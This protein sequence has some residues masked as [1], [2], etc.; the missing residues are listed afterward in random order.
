MPEARSTRSNDVR[1]RNV[2]KKNQLRPVF[3][4][5][6]AG[7]ILLYVGFFDDRWSYG[8]ISCTNGRESA[9][10]ACMSSLKSVLIQY[11]SD[12]SRFPHLK[13]ISYST[14]RVDQENYDEAEIVLEPLTASRNVLL[15]PVIESFPD[16]DYPGILSES[17]QKRWKGP[18][19][20]SKFAFL[21]I[22]ATGSECLG[23]TFR[24]QG[25]CPRNNSE[26][27]NSLP[28]RNSTNAL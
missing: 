23:N 5:I 28:C 21:D 22:C 17:Y 4:G 15:Q 1:E 26:A 10:R 8:D 14:F 18:D 2:T 9:P 13:R 19:L 16:W 27:W 25:I 24:D 12:L 3:Q 11:Q 6:L 7:G 20:T